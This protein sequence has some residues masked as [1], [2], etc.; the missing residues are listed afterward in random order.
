MGGLSTT[1]ITA[2]GMPRAHP[3]PMQPPRSEPLRREMLALFSGPLGPSR[4]LP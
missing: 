2:P 4:L 1:G 3:S